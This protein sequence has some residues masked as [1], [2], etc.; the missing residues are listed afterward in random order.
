M[1][2][3]TSQGFDEYE[4]VNSRSRHL[5]GVTHGKTPSSKS[6]RRCHLTNKKNIKFYKPL[7]IHA[8]SLQVA[9][10]QIIKLARS[11][12]FSDDPALVQSL[13]PGVAFMNQHLMQELVKLDAKALTIY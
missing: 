4:D 6:D 12:K 2:R 1:N 9:Y 11:G 5:P 8:G 10:D 7:G 13:I 3:Y